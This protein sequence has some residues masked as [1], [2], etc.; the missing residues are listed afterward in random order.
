MGLIGGTDFPRIHLI[1][2]AKGLP[3]YTAAG[4]RQ[5]TSNSS[6]PLCLDEFEDEGLGDKKGRVV[7]ETFEMFRNLNGENNTYTMG[8]RGG[9]PVT[10]TLN[11]PVFVAAI[12]KA[13]KVQD[14][15]RTI[16]VHL[17]KVPH[18]DDPQQ[19]L[20]QTY[21]IMALEQL[22]KDLAI[23]LLPHAATLQKIYRE[24]E[25]EFGQNAR[26]MLDQRYMEG[27]YPALS[28][29]KFLGQDYRKFLDEWTDANKD[30]FKFG[31]THTD[32]MELFHYICQS[33]KLPVRNPA[34]NHEK[35]YVPLIQL[36][37]TPETREQINQ[38]N[39]GLYFDEVQQVLV[40]SWNAAVQVVLSQHA[41]YSRES[42]LF[43]LR[44]LANRAPNVVPTEEL[45]ST[46][47]LARLKGQGIGAIPAAYLTGYRMTE[48]INNLS[49]VAPLPTDTPTQPVS[50]S[51]PVAQ[52]LDLP[53]KAVS[54]D[55]IEFD[56]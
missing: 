28:M 20:I 2:A 56:G 13:K 32:S 23:L 37:A 16:M 14:A 40:V 30:A 10:Y 18:R 25:L 51:A 19:I 22:K 27:L 6:R 33:P 41:K 54:S 46:G 34:N 3:S 38:T 42:N 7:T 31:A 9:D 12:N 39:S 35:N 1:A 47:V 53:K 49:S 5:S 50:A 21:G 8:Q 55:N 24:I 44:D 17:K 11:Y 15:N 52:V 45:I 4:I 36:L 29:M 43:N 48:T 26:R